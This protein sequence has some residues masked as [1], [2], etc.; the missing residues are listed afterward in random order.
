MVYTLIY[1]HDVA[2]V[3]VV[4]SAAKVYVG[5]QPLVDAHD[6]FT[7]SHPTTEEQFRLLTLSIFL[8]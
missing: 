5:R 4:P 6:V 3:S 1:T 7:Y 2:I 8:I